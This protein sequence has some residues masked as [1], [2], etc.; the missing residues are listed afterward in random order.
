MSTDR[1]QPRG[2]HL[3]GSVPFASSEDVFRAAASILGDHLRRM[4][5]GETGVRGN[6]IDWQRAVFADHPAFEPG[7][8]EPGLYGPGPRFR[9]R[10]RARAGDLAFSALGYADAAITS[11]RRFERLR[12]AGVV[13]ARMRFQ[14]SLPTPLAPLTF[15]VALN[16]RALA[17]LAYER[18]MLAEL[19]GML[20]VM[21][22]ARL[23]VQ[24]DV[25]VE[26]GLL[27][28]L[29]PTHLPDPWEDAA[30][31]LVRLGQAVPSEV[32]LGYH[33]CYGD[34]A[35]RH[36]KEPA[37][38]GLLVRLANAVA[39][40]LVRPLTW[41]HL[42][43]PRARDDDAYFAPLGELRLPP[44][45]EVYLGLVHHHDGIAGAE[46]RIAAARR[47]L[48][49]FGVATECGLGRRPAETIP[50]LLRIHAAVAAPHLR[51]AAC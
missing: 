38:S 19:D 10:G 16:D 33:L 12:R 27:E 37:D 36:F 46:R 34:L 8:D 13:P 7:P 9:L 44:G 15:F 20:A 28:G 39:A 35:H 29:A 18:R 50:E 23:A 2:A 49:R 14:V 21:P 40:R 32:E 4:P 24:W 48:A 41:I 25:A 43:V 5:D 3:V 51:P 31:R 45:A 42:P 22:A 47:H 26:V 6:W 11:Y 1:E 17:E 30:E